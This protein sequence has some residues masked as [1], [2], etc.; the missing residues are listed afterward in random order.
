MKGHWR[1]LGRDLGAVPRLGLAVAVLLAA[2][3]ASSEVKIRKRP[4]GGLHVYNVGGSPRAAAGP[5]V[6]AARVPATGSW[7]ERREQHRPTIER[8]AR[9]AGLEPKLVMAVV[10][11]ESSYNPSAVSTKGA[12]G[13]MQLMPATAAMYSVTDPYDPEQNVRAGTRYLKR[14]LDRFGSVEL[15]LA[16]YNAG[17]E[18]VRS[19]GGIPPYRET[20]RYVERILREYRGDD[21]FRLSRTGRVS[22]GRRTYLIRD[23]S[24]RLVMTTTRPSRR[25]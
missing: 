25:P 18:A 6:P 24:G 1:R 12:M 8:F 2:S 11:A 23:A 4:D 13:L 9:V 5:A 14:M 7:S 22:R 21:S 15:A 16:A 10:A 20:E 17:P 19:F 3:P